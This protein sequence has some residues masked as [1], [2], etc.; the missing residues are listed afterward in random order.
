MKKIVPTMLLLCTAVF[1]FAQQ[2]VTTLNFGNGFLKVT[3][4]A[5]NAVRIQ[6]YEKELSDAGL[7]DW[8][9]EGRATAVDNC[10][11]NI[12]INSQ[13]QLL[14]IKNANGTPVFTATKRLTIGARK[15]KYAAS[16][17]Q[18]IK[19]S[20]AGGAEKEIIYRGKRLEVTPQTLSSEVPQ[21]V[22]L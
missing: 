19:I 11:L 13:Q 12:D 8:L 2:K 14:T 16:K 20:V 22:S 17:I 7:P 6:Y 3:P 9:Y 21:C 5:R 15:G 4:V 18:K 10:N 1:G